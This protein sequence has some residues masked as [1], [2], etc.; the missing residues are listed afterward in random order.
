MQ[1]FIVN[2]STDQLNIHVWL[3]RIH[4][5]KKGLVQKTPSTHYY[6]GTWLVKQQEPGAEPTSQIQ[7]GL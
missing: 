5:P 7:S 3:G 1:L 2:K 4:T 6:E